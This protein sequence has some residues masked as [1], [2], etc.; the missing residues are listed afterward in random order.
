MYC[1][2]GETNECYRCKDGFDDFDG[3][4]LEKC[5]DN[6]IR[7]ENGQCVNATLVDCPNVWGC[8]KC[9]QFNMNYCAVCNDTFRKS[10]VHPGTCVCDHD[11]EYVDNKCVRPAGPY[12]P[13]PINKTELGRLSKESFTT[14]NSD[15]GLNYTLSKIEGVSNDNQ[16]YY[17]FGTDS[18]AV[19]IPD[20]FKNKEYFFDIQPR[21]KPFTIQLP[22]ETVANVEC[23]GDSTNLKIPADNKKVNLYG[24]GKVTLNPIGDENSLTLNNVILEP[25]SKNLVLDSD[26]SNLTL[27]ILDITGNKECQGQQSTGNDVFQTTCNLVKVEARSEFTPKNIK[28]ENIKV[29]LLSLINIDDTVNIE[30]A[31][32]ILYHNNN[33]YGNQRT[34]LVFSGSAPAKTGE[35]HIE[36]LD[37]GVAVPTEQE[38]FSVAEFNL[39]N[40]DDSKK[41]CDEMLKDF[42]GGDVFSEDSGKCVP[43]ENDKNKAILVA[44]REYNQKNNDDDKGGLSAGAIAGIVIACVVVVAAI[45]ALLVYFLVIKKKNQSTTSTQGDSS[46]AI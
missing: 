12:V 28:L 15:D 39:K 4:C 24:G 6:F 32:I 14:S 34:P 31:N 13:P 9:P 25:Q 1:R 38:N 18:G 33:H 27:L 10:R 23:M 16:L 37:E 2:D 41:A 43:D 26:K 44:T 30:N 45:I 7:N 3:K 22:P 40:Y 11:H 21:N 20:D 5:K 29:G 17:P 35:I 42:K 8:K 36:K 19:T 46:I